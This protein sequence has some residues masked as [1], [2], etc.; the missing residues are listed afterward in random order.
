MAKTFYKLEDA[1]AF[2]RNPN[3]EKQRRKNAQTRTA[4]QNTARTERRATRLQRE[5][6]C[7]RGCL[8]KTFVRERYKESIYAH[9]PNPGEQA[10]EQMK[11]WQSDFFKEIPCDA[12][13]EVPKKNLYGKEITSDYKTFA[14]KINKFNLTQEAKA[15][16]IR[17]HHV[18]RQVYNA[19]IF[20][21][22]QRN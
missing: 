6:D 11:K 5:P 18:F 16:L 19:T 12:R 17:A 10:A 4:Q 20:F 22:K 3:D 21:I 9:F 15:V 7:R 13:K 14:L 1:A 2:V 8:T